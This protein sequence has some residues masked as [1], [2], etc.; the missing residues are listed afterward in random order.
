VFGLIAAGMP[1]ADEDADSVAELTAWGCVTTDPDDEN[2]LVALNPKV[3]AR[4]RLMLDA[5][6]AMLRLERMR[7]LPEVADELYGQY[8]RVQ[9]RAGGGAEY[10]AD[11]AVVNARLDDVV[12][13]A[14]REIL[15]AQP[16]G[17]RSQMQLG[18]SLDRDT[19]ALERGVEKRTIYR[20]TVRDNPVTAEY[21]RA[22]S[23]R[24]SGRS[25][26][27]VTLAEPFERIIIVDRQTAFVSNHLVAGGPEHAAWQV[28]DQAVIA[29]MVEEFD[30]KWRR[31]DPWRGEVRGRGLAAD[32]GLGVDGVRT[33]PRQREVMRDMVAGRDQRATATR[34]GVSERTV[35]GEINALKD[36]FDAES[37]EQLAFKWAFSP[38]RL[39]GVSAVETGRVDVQTAA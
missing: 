11:P 23:H 17:P 19:A 7:C 22:M 35:S 4:R 16:A 37:R 14:Q 9:L 24:P 33:T 2:R 1:V 26:Q 36:L 34:L 10:I 38:D 31:A 28:S 25:A 32:V 30:A 12:G 29:Y 15:S 13:G 20:A 8:Q 21:A 5:E 6:E 39:V 27:F 3:A 18:R